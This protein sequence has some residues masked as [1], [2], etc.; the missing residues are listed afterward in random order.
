M[1]PEAP[2]PKK[3]TIFNAEL[4]TQMLAERE[5]P[6]A[7]NYQSTTHSTN[8]DALQAAHGSAHHRTVFLSDEQTN[9]RGREG[10]SWFSEPGASLTF[11]VLFR[12]GWEARKTSGFALAVGLAVR[13][14][15]SPWTAGAPKIKWPN[16]V[17]YENKKLAG[18]LVETQIRG[19]YVGALVVGIGVNVHTETFP[20]EVARIATSLR[21]AAPQQQTR[22]GNAAV[23][24]VH[25]GPPLGVRQD[26]P[27]LTRELV[28]VE[29]LKQLDARYLEFAK[30]GVPG[31]LANLTEFDALFGERIEVGHLVGVAAGISREGALRLR[32][33]SGVERLIQSGT[34]RR[35]G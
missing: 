28:L 30:T 4:A 7:L 3:Q 9:G 20:E 34:V 35:V 13:D 21:L 19:A 33:D 16:D 25:Q 17:L 10:R 1:K 26:P 5:L 27:A 11:S 12:P 32:L 15:L 18:I 2:S 23:L 29:I 8:D 24:G 6:Y 14:A 22:T 31:V